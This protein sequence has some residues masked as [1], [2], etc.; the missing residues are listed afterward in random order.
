MEKNPFFFFFFYGKTPFPRTIC[1]K[2]YRRRK[3][4]YTSKSF[5]FSS[6]SQSSYKTPNHSSIVL[7]R[8][9]SQFWGHESNALGAWLC[10]NP[11][12]FPPKLLSSCLCFLLL[13]RTYGDFLCTPSL[14]CPLHR[15]ECWGHPFG[16]KKRVHHPFSLCFMTLKPHGAKSQLYL[17]GFS[18]C[19]QETCAHV[20]VVSRHQN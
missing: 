1:R 4:K 3:K 8:K 11:L 6:F 5:L 14:L 12:T 18:S 19:P 20:D 10:S 7:Q 9:S 2:G 17:F 15:A 16:T 13:S